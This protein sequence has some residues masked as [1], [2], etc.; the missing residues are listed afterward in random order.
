[1][2]RFSYSIVS[3][4]VSAQSTCYLNI[5][6]LITDLL[7]TEILDVGKIQN[8]VSGIPWTYSDFISGHFLKGQTWVAK[9][10]KLLIIHVLLV[11]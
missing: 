2:K 1:M 9:L 3:Q 6:V 7:V 4:K 8:I 5:K 11:I 10:V